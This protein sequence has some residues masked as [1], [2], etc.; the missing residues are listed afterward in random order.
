[1]DAATDVTSRPGVAISAAAAVVLT[2][3]MAGAEVVRASSF[4]SRPLGDGASAWPRW[5]WWPI[6]RAAV[7]ARDGALLR[8]AGG[9]VLPRFLASEDGVGHERVDGGRRLMAWRF[10]AVG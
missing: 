8:P 10:R 2:A 4:Q 3:V 9:W 1:M 6:G 5:H 7:G